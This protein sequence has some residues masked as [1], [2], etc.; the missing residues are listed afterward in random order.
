MQSWPELSILEIMILG[1]VC[2]FY[3]GTDV[4]LDTV[5]QHPCHSLDCQFPEVEF[6]FID[7]SMGR[8]CILLRDSLL[9]ILGLE[10]LFHKIKS[11]VNPARKCMRVVVSVAPASPERVRM[12][13]LFPSSF[14]P[15]SID[16]AGLQIPH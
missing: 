10:P 14:L 2:D 5:V 1:C 12:W 9:K 4:G 8:P 15:G 7:P 6:T 13:A 11:R 3:A 16:L